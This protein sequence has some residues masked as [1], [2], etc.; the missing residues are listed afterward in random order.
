M[1]EDA[2]GESVDRSRDTSNGGPGVAACTLGAKTG[3]NVKGQGSGGGA[4][5]ELL[6]QIFSRT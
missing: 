2:L 4:P 5:V 3:G 6:G 1:S